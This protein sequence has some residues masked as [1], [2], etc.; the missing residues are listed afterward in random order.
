MQAPL[1]EVAASA[2]P[3]E[4]VVAIAPARPAPQPSLAV[5]AVQA[6]AQAR[7]AYP[8]LLARVLGSLLLPLLALA[9]GALLRW[10]WGG[11]AP[12]WWGVDGLLALP[13]LLGQA[14]ALWHW[15]MG[16]A[17]FVRGV[18]L[19]TLL[20]GLALGVWLLLIIEPLQRHGL[21][22]T[23]ALSQGTPWEGLAVPFSWALLACAVPLLGLA[24]LLLWRLLAQAVLEARLAVSA[25]HDLMWVL[26][27]S[28]LAVALWALWAPLQLPGAPPLDLGDKPWAVAAQRLSLFVDGPALVLLTFAVTYVLSRLAVGALSLRREQS[29]LRPDRLLPPLVLLDLRSPDD[30]PTRA[31]RDLHALANTWG[32]A[33]GPVLLLRA[34][35]H[36]LQGGGQH[37]RWAQAA[38]RLPELFVQGP[39]AARR[40]CASWL[41]S[42]RGPFVRE[43]LL[44]QASDMRELA[45]ALRGAAPGALFVVL[46]G[47]WLMADEVERLRLVLPKARS[48]CLVQANPR[49]QAPARIPH[50][51]GSLHQPWQ[52]Q[53]LV[54]VLTQ[55]LLAPQAQQSLAVIG[56]PR[57][58]RL[59][60]ALVAV[61]DQQPLPG[62]DTLLDA[63]RPARDAQVGFERLLLLLDPA[64]LA[65]E[66]EALVEAA[67]L[68]SWVGSVP[69][70]A[71]LS[72]GAPGPAPTQQALDRAWAA[73]GGR[74]TLVYAG[75]LPEDIATWVASG[76]RDSLL[77][78][79][80]A[81]V[82][83]ERVV[84][85]VDE[86]D[87]APPLSPS[88]P[89]APAMP[90]PEAVVA[91]LRPLSDY[92]F[93][94]YLSYAHADDQT[95]SGWVGHFAHELEIG[96][97]ATL[98]GIKLPP[99][100]LSGRDGPMAGD[101]GPHMAERLSSA[102][103]L[104]IV[105]HDHY[106]RSEWCL[107]ELELFA[108]QRAGTNW[109]QQI[110]IVA[111]SEPA[112]QVVTHSPRWQELMAGHEAI[113]LPFYEPKQ[114]DRPLPVYVDPGVVSAQFRE[115][116]QR[117]RLDMAQRLRQAA[118]LPAA[119][120]TAGRALRIYVESSR[121]EPYLW[122]ALT[123]Q[124]RRLWD[125]LQAS[126]DGASDPS[127]RLHLQ[128]LPLDAERDMRLGDADG[129]VLLVGTK[130]AT[131]LHSQIESA[132]SRLSSGRLPGLLVGVEMTRSALSLGPLHWPL[133]LLSA[134]G[135]RG[136]A[137]GL[138]A[139]Q[140]GTLTQF[141][142]QVWERHLARAEA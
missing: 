103:M 131:L 112:V 92:R 21:S 65:G 80:P 98:R 141:L 52:R 12:R 16:G 42:G 77:H 47:S 55:R 138:D 20:G 82:S 130:S 48:V 10:L 100:Y 40:W 107:K 29:A 84:M 67:A 32:Q 1:P 94:A 64:W 70:V 39:D 88:P 113:W 56:R 120:N 22:T 11:S 74:G 73:C 44:S 71:A 14:A 121:E 17:V 101:I 108:A 45:L 78:F 115:P 37:Q 13:L 31:L 35:A 99:L 50:L 62:S 36:A 26:C 128:G 38:R 116:F 5:K 81:P 83:V 24:C 140:L 125:E 97:Q 33:R 132:E 68:Q 111:L 63:Q 79:A 27:V 4:P 58:D 89:A 122:E 139:E 134:S 91:A 69:M 8:G 90:P 57:S 86:F 46:P 95:W 23:L 59:A 3:A 34:A 117:L 19:F 142:R 66:A 126:W 76:G 75:H 102:F 6:A 30:C 118:Q 124:M 72:T 15:F 105:I 96:T 61:L 135:Q 7:Q 136:E 60:D 49:M 127:Q 119:P 123:E 51:S 114:R 133:L 104:I 106:V 87:Q 9:L 41:G 53:A 28:A 43:C 93:C 137:A 54:T 129:V 85:E 109:Q 110:Y 2:A 25:A 18:R